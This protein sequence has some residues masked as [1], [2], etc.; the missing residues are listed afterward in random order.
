MTARYAAGTDVPA[1]RSRE[2]IETVVTRYGAD[3]FLY[4]WGGAG[5]VGPEGAAVVQFRAHGRYVR[6]L[7]PM[8]DRADPEFTR[9]PTGKVRKDGAAAGRAWEQATRQR[10]RALLLNIT[11]KLEAVEIGLATFEQEVMANIVLPDGS[12]VSDFM[13]PQI[14]RAYSTREM[15]SM[16]PA[17][18]S[19]RG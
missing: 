2:Q 13:T 1:A 11:A 17:L 15:P 14:E 3:Q 18:E 16:F 6:F 4:G 19:G 7:L 8:P 10:W 9:T 12:T 5:M